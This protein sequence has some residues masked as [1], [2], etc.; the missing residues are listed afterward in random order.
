M[1]FEPSVDFPCFKIKKR[2]IHFSIFCPQENKSIKLIPI[3]KKGVE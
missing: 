3:W 2:L 1:G